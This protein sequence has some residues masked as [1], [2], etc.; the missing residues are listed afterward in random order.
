MK[1]SL[2]ITTFNRDSLLIR[3]LESILK[4][5]NDLEI[6]ILN[7]GKDIDTSDI[8]KRYDVTHIHTALTKNHVDDWRVP[9]F[10]LNIGAR[11]ATGEILII[12]CAEMYHVDNCIEQLVKA[13][14]ANPNLLA[15][16]EGRDDDGTFDG[17]NWSKLRPLN[18][19]LPFLMAVSKKN[20]I[21]IGGY[22]EDFTGISYED[23]DFIGRMIQIGCKYL[24]VSAMCIHLYHER[25]CY[26]PESKPKE[27]Y[28]KK[29]YLERRGT[30]R[31][32]IDKD[33]GS[34]R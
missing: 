24:K 7:D 34:F 11:K 20:F 28:N 26:A 10:A 15:I 21:D 18:T 17:H 12:S 16:T 22:D 31:R 5:K 9:G 30:V 33:W 23:N 4:F 19:N 32:N 13:F 14:Y 27:E 6:I 3:G 8:A 25:I 2:L 1:T 29:L